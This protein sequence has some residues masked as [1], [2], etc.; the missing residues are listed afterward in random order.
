SSFAMLLTSATFIAYQYHNFQGWTNQNLTAQAQVIG[1]SAKGVLALADPEAGR[2]AL[3][4]L[5]SQAVMTGAAL[6]DAHGALLSS[7]QRAGSSSLPATAPGWRGLRAENND[8]YLA[9]SI[10]EKGANLGTIILRSSQAEGS[11]YLR[12]SM[13]TLLV[14]VV[15]T[16]LITM[17]LSSWLQKIIAGPVTHLA[18]VM[19]RVSRHQDYGLR[20]SRYADDELGDLSDFLNKMLA[21][22]EK[23]DRQLRAS[24]DELRRLRNY[25]HN[26]IDS[27]PSALIGLDNEGRVS[28]WNREALG[29][30]GCF[31][32]AGKGEMLAHVLPQ[33]AGQMSLVERAISQ[34]RVQE[35]K[36][37][38][39][40][41]A[42]ELRYKDITIYPLMA[43]GVGGGAVLR[44]DDVT[45]EVRLAEMMVQT[46]KMMSVGGL[47]AG[48]AHEINNP[49]GIMVQAVQNIERR[50]EPKLAVNQE[51]AAEL[52]LDL[53]LVA[54]YLEGRQINSL[55]GD[56]RGAGQRAAR[57]VRNMLQFSRRSDSSACQP[58]QVVELIE[59]SLEL[60]RNDYDLKKRFDFRNIEIERDYD[61]QLPQVGLVETEF[62]QVILN[63]LR[64]AAQAFAEQEGE[65]VPTIWLGAHQEKDHVVVRVADNGP[66]MAD[67][68]RK[69]VFEPFFTTKPEG[70]GTGLG[71]SVSYMIITN[72]HSGS[73]TVE[74]R[75]GQGTEF[76]IRLPRT[77]PGQ[78]EERPV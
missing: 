41:L 36:K 56:I 38:R 13:A 71:L 42:G 67:G 70:S 4:V 19:D 48:M 6:Y 45:E 12:K 59:K 57:I 50:L 3:S 28:R 33:F 10:Q 55:L 60:A 7:W 11:S 34:G 52:G 9:R 21:R 32:E 25:L 2:A 78:G 27:M 63:L 22:V 20:A 24:E 1:A 14:L 75:P 43:D 16:G 68:V 47:A 18:T 8:S 74:S 35:V 53:Q 37:F 29:L 46:E 61:P 26:V 62:E 73:M 76:T 17:L 72:N 49:L 64:N 58:G 54:A 31:S 77:A 30:G 23:R 15:L 40:E 65:S 66:G 44:V 5:S 69:R 39:Y 51:R